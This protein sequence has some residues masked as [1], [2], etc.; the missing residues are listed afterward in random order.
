MK[1]IAIQSSPNL[2]GLTSSLAQAVLNGVRNERGSA[3]LI[4]LNKLNLKPCI[5]CDNG[6]GKCRDKGICVHEDDFQNL[7]DKIAKCDALVFATPVYWH[8][9]S[10]S[11]KIFLDRLR[12]CETGLG[13]KTF[14]GKKA[15][16]I[17]SAGGS[18]QGAIRALYNL[19]DYLRRLGFD[20]FDLVP[21]TRFSKDHKLEMLEK[22]GRRLI[23]G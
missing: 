7:T 11:A 14:A 5:A 4:H 16:G 12:R 17:A 22:A 19:E 23:R 1:V 2:D 3:E 8:D 13:F 21:V 6:W 9:L 20:I 15:I 10:E 18:G